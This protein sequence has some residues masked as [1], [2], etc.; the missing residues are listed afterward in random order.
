MHVGAGRA[1]R[2][3]LIFDAYAYDVGLELGCAYIYGSIAILI[4]PRI[5]GAGAGPESEA[6]RTR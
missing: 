3:R 5:R 6:Q 1:S 4:Q 2:P